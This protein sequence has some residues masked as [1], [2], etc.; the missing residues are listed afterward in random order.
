[1]FGFGKG[2]TGRR[3]GRGRQHKKCHGRRIAHALHMDLSQA[4]IGKKYLILFI[5]TPPSL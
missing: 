5:A 2:G 1:M 4:E 3:Q